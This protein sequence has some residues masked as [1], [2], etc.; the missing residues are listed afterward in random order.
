MSALQSVNRVIAAA[1]AELR[2]ARAAGDDAAGDRIFAEI[3]SPLARIAA[4]MAL[5]DLASQALAL[6]AASAQLERA[7]ADLERSVDRMFLDDIRATA[8]ELDMVAEKAS[9]QTAPAAAV[10]PPAQPSPAPEPSPAS[11]PSEPSAPAQAAAPPA[12]ASPPTDRDAYAAAFKAMA[13]RPD[14][15]GRAD[16]AARALLRPDAVT[17]YR[18]VEARTGAPWWFVG[19]LH[20]MEAS[21]NFN[22]HL[23]NGD[24]LD[25][26]TVRHPPGRPFG[27]R[28]GM[29]WEESAAD[30]LTGEGRL[31]GVRDWSVGAALEQAERWNGLGY[32]R[33]GLWSPFLWSG[34]TYYSRGRFVADGVFDPDADSAQAGVAVLLR[35]LAELDVLQTPKSAP[36]VVR[37]ASALTAPRAPA[38]DLAP[39]PHAADEL[40]FPMKAGETIQLGM[41]LGRR[42]SAANKA[43]VRKVQ[44]WLSFHGPILVVDGEFGDATALAVAEFQRRAA[45][46]ET[47]EVD[48]ELWALL[49][50][51]MRAA[52]DTEAEIGPGARPSL[53]EQ[54]VLVAQAH[55]AQKPREIGG[56]N[57]GPWVRLY[58]SG[59]QSEDGQSHAWCA[60]FAC[61]IVAQAARDLGME[62]PFKRR[63]R[64]ADLARDAK[65]DGRFVDGETMG[66]GAGRAA[67][68]PIGGLFVRRSGASWN[69]TGLVTS[70]ADAVFGTVEGNTTG[71]DRD[72]DSVKR[73]R[74]SYRNYDFVRL[75]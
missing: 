20:L 8:A 13:I 14:W 61:F 2:A 23:H 18:A 66:D 34:S 36:A 65:A 10:E 6:N 59:E 22:R 30:A 29:S 25:A 64:V 5:A 74:H 57:R 31:D 45:L 38:P 52:L 4:N 15:E 70:V 19:A 55:V 41:G 7:L 27:W 62:A 44:E 39:F 40:D 69:H 53:A 11:A 9:T 37:P 49:T 32:R 28:P 72:G 68:T 24:P 46:P 12:P 56:N 51:P 16:L 75:V 17:R 48:E 21:Q 47:G 1:R 58:M 26:P 67:R 3:V 33:R 43:K 50:A 42:K 73:S 63:I 71:Q 60:G 54:A 35:R